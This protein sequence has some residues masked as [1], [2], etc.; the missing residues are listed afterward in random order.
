MSNE[1]LI[2]LIKLGIDKKNNME[3]LYIQNQGMIYAVVKRY[4]YACQSDHNNTSIIEVEDL[5]HEAYFGLLKAVESYDTGQ[6]VLFM[7]YAPYWI[8][9][10]VKRYLEN[11][12]QAVRVPVH[13]QAQV[14]QYNQATS[15]FL[16]KYNRQPS[17]KEYATWLSVSE[18]AVE[19][20]QRF[21]FQ[22][23]IKSLDIPLPGSDNVELTI[24]DT[25]ASEVDIE[26]EVTERLSRQQLY[27][28]LWKIVKE[29]LKDEKALQIL[30]I[31]YKDGPMS[32]FSTN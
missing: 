25:I 29:E 4:R 6:G 7:S 5:M 21:M 9:R 30:K 11:C 20:L 2:K 18:K 17:V 23:K 31:K 14:Y 27:S 15:C 19:Q 24:I 32:R 16:R 22:S 28:E 13:K 3:Q 12:G 26:N 10:A 8:K 1:E